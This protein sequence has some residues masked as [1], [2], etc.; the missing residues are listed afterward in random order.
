MMKLLYPKARSSFSDGDMMFIEETLASDDHSRKSLRNLMQ[1]QD[2]MD[3]VLDNSKLLDA[4]LAGRGSGNVSVRLFYYL[5]IRYELRH[6][7]MTDRN[8]AD[9]MT[10]FLI[11]YVPEPRM[12][13]LMSGGAFDYRY[14][15]GMKQALEEANEEQRFILNSRIANYSLMVCALCPE[16]IRKHL[17]PGVPQANDPEFFAE[18]CSAHFKLA[19]EHRLAWEH[20]LKEIYREID[21][22][23]PAI[24]SA[25]S[26]FAR[27]FLLV[28]K[29]PAEKNVVKT[30]R[31]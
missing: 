15:I 22:R 5:A 1:H 10:E 23:W 8:V 21:R 11:T 16:R 14:V 20:D 31:D 3:I 29:I 24:R 17:I 7:G 13:I 9:Y 18:L 6:V 30:L 4:V 28:D 27:Q 25:L 12:G 19:A 2:M 26:D